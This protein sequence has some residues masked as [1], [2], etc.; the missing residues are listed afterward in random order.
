MFSATESETIPTWGQTLFEIF[1]TCR[2]FPGWEMIR[3]LHDKSDQAY[4]DI[5]EEMRDKGKVATIPCLALKTLG[6][7]A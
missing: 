1:R 2:E 7:V 6:P 3:S 4:F 5:L